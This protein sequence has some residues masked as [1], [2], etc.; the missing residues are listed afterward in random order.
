MKENVPSETTNLFASSAV[1]H[2]EKHF[3]SERYALD[4]N[5]SKLI[6]TY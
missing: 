1:S 5:I 2:L 6:H 4:G 3:N